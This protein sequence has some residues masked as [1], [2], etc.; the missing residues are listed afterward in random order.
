[1]FSRCQIALGLTLLLTLLTSIT[2]FAK[3]SFA[4]ITISGPDL[5]EPIRSTNPALTT[6][7]FAFAEF[8]QN[9]T[10]APA[11]PGVGYEV[12]RYYIDSGRDLAFDHLHYYP[13]TGYVFFDGL[14]NGSSEYDGKW[15]PAHPEIK[16]IFISALTSAVTVKTE[17][18]SSAPQSQPIQPNT[19]PK[20][21]FPMI[22]M[23]SVI[24][25]STILVLGM[26]AVMVYRRRRSTAH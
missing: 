19:L 3:G 10:K 15:Y 6:D 14:V 24:L 23:Q 5:K 18:Q 8:Y 1:M 21:G 20:A 26:L 7:F 4:F 11:D 17:P 22:G 9:E 25:L 13:D 2:V 16:A 12:T